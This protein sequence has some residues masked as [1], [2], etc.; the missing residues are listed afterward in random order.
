MAAGILIPVLFCFSADSSW[1]CSQ[2]Y[3]SLC[4]VRLRAAE[5]HGLGLEFNRVSSFLP[6]VQKKSAV[7]LVLA[8]FSTVFT[9]SPHLPEQKQKICSTVSLY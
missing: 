3:S 1:P 2:P 5:W 9:F 8:E 4:A 7:P 6:V